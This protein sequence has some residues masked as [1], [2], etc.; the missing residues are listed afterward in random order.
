MKKRI[1]YIDIA[2]GIC[3]ILVVLQH[4]KTYNRSLETGEY[5]FE[6]FRMPLFFM[7]SGLFFKD[8][9]Q[10]EEFFRKKI[11]TLVIPFLFFY[12]TTSV[13]LPNLLY[14]AGYE[15]LRQSSKLGWTSI[16]NCFNEKLY[17][18][19]ALW[20]LLALFWMNIILYIIRTISKR[21]FSGKDFQVSAILCVICGL[22]GFVLGVYGVF[23]P[24]NIDNALT[25]IPYF[26]MGFVFASKINLKESGFNKV[27]VSL[28]TVLCFIIVAA[29]SPGIGYNM[30]VFQKEDFIPLYFSGIIGSLGIIGM[31][32][33][34]KHSNILSFYGRNTMLMLCLQMP[35]IQ[36]V[37]MFTKV[38]GGGYFSIFLTLIIVII[39]FIPLFGLFNKY[40]P[41]AIGKT[42]IIKQR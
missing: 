42:K 9:I 23:I 1:E 16:F 32:I 38:N 41:W 34:I 14:L 21:C 31:S 8:N 4:I 27:K 35:I 30:N 20:F 7:L 22:L 36:V 11:K 26:F 33:L 40:I 15:G 10:F 24:L 12:I 29:F 39:I 6:A 37:N 19:A 28:L 3:M 13:L 17:S 2:K 25:S 5:F 18:N